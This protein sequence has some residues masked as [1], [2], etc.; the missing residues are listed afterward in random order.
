VILI[1]H[2]LVKLGHQI[3]WEVFDD[4]WGK[5]F[6]SSRASDAD[7]ADRRASPSEAHEEVV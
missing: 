6:E 7:E 2:E 3:P 5:L 4:A 1:D